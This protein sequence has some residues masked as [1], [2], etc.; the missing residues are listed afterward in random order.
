MSK[1]INQG[2]DY[3]EDLVDEEYDEEGDEDT[4][5]KLTSLFGIPIKF[6]ILGGAV[7]L[8]LLIIVVV[9]ALRDS[10]DDDI[11]LPENTGEVVQQD[12]NTQVPQQPVT[13]DPNVQQQPV[14]QE[15]SLLIWMDVAGNMVGISGSSE[16]G[17]VVTLDG[18]P[19][20]KISLSGGT[21]VTSDTGVSAYI[22][23]MSVAGFGEQTQQDE[24]DIV[25]TLRKLGYTGDEI[26]A[27][28]NAG[29]DLNA[30]A[31]EAQKLR[32]EEAKE[33]LVRMSDSASEEFLH[34]ANYSVFSMPFIEFPETEN[35]FDRINLPGSYIVNADYEKVDT[36]GNQLYIK[37][38]IAN[39]TYAF[40]SLDPLRWSEIPSSGNMVVKITYTLF[41]MKNT[42][43]Q[44]YITDITE[45]DVAQIT[46]NPEDSATDLNDIINIDSLLAGATE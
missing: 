43:V 37:L 39:G 35:S 46:V 10:G 21:P 14:Q 42:T 38:K 30:M 18:N 6:L 4:D 31:E 1:V 15:E 34:M 26:Q 20:G 25:T 41:G 22:Q 27:A 9:F 11:V 44:F 40:M 45:M 28:Q 19:V 32:D 3:E 7:L 8:L 16:E 12:P 5:A 24:L 33:A 13:T 23:A 36:Y 29:A 17:S 2:E